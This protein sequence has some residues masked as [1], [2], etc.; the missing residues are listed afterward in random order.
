M[1]LATAALSGCGGNSGSGTKAET[2]TQ[3]GASA[4]AAMPQELTLGF[5]PS[6]E[7]DKLAD[8]AQP[9]AD[10]LSKEIGIPVKSFTATTYVGLVEGMGSGKVDIGALAPLA[11]VLAND[12]SGAQVILK[13][14]R[15]GAMTYHAMFIARADSGIKKVEDAKGKRVAFV[16]PASAS[17]YLFPAAHLKNKNI[18]PE[19]YFGQTMY[20]GGHDKSVIAVY[21][22]DVD[23]AAVFDD[24]RAIVAKNAAYKDVNSKVVKV[25]QTEE[26]PNDTIAVRKGLD[27]VLTAKIKAAFLK[28]A[29]SPEGKKTLTD[30]YEID[31][32]TAAT[33]KEYDV[34][35]RT[36]RLMG[37]GLSS[38]K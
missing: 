31:G 33:D 7:A 18:D 35:R 2:Q 30:L 36:A 12:Q 1:C 32:M 4:G 34:V 29:Q 28:Y 17:G 11:Y 21:N 3:G 37:V 10:F 27:P 38:L 15:R 25:G 24:A 23:M 16:D 13:S 8:T 20:S 9:L 19:K 5:V 22:G 26:I 14:S 6:Q